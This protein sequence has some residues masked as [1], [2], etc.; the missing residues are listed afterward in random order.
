MTNLE[1]ELLELDKQL[2]KCPLYGGLQYELQNSKIRLIVGSLKNSLHDCQIL[3]EELQGKFKLIKYQGKRITLATA[4]RIWHLG[5]QLEDLQGNTYRTCNN[6]ECFNPVHLVSSK[7]LRYLQAT[8]EAPINAPR[9][10]A[11][12]KQAKIISPSKPA[13]LNEEDREAARIKKEK[14]DLEYAENFDYNSLL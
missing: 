6:V 11:T 14:G 8:G 5:I 4:I 13:F 12:G 9:D 1:L 3:P 2:R 7:E 10:L